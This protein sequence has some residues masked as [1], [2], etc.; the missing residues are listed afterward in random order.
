MSEEIREFVMG[1]KITVTTRVEH[2]ANIARIAV[3]YRLEN[4]PQGHAIAFTKGAS[5]IGSESEQSVPYRDRTSKA[6]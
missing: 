3:Y 4:D 2:A 1:D 5:R 6:R